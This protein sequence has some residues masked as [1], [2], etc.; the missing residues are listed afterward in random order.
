MWQFCAAFFHAK[1]SFLKSHYACRPKSGDTSFKIGEIRSTSFGNE[2]SG[3]VSSDPGF[4]LP[5][6]VPCR[7][8]QSLYPYIKVVSYVRYPPPKGYN[9][10]TFFGLVM[11]P[12]LFNFVSHC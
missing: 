12:L 5:V 7:A 2:K 3:G 1:M 10:I 8:L 9:F 4:S 11:D 6:P